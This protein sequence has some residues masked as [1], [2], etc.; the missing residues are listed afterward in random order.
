MYS[1]DRPTE[2][3][4]THVRYTVAWGNERGGWC[5]Y[6]VLSSL[7]MKYISGP[8]PTSAAAEKEMP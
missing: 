8:Y 5:V 6:E 4:S 2:A 3:G 7:E 1:R